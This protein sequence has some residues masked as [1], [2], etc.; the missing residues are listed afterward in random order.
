MSSAAGVPPHVPQPAFIAVPFVTEDQVE[1]ACGHAADLHTVEDIRLG[2]MKGIDAE[3]GLYWR[4][5]C[6]GWFI[7]RGGAYGTGSEC[8]CRSVRSVKPL[9]PVEPELP[10]V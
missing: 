5:K 7:P 8:T 9:P 1:C 4:M 2:P 6:P 10:D 3:T